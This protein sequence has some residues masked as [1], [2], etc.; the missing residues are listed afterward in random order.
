MNLRETMPVIP[1]Q[2]NIHERLE[3]ESPYKSWN[4]SKNKPPNFPNE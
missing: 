4:A 1:R 3:M 2:K